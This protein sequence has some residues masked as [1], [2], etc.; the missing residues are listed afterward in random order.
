M[1][2]REQMN[3]K[4]ALTGGVVIGVIVIAAAWLVHW[5][6]A[7]SGVVVRNQ[8]YFSDDDGK[9]YYSDA[10]TNLAPYTHNGRDAVIAHVFQ[11]GSNPPFI[12]YLEKFTD[13]MK[14]QM[15]QQPPPD[16]DSDAGTLVK[17]PG[18][19]DWELVTDSAGRTIRLSIVP[20]AGQPGQPV[21]VVP[22]VN[23]A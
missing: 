1:G 2:L 19:K 15:S 4:P 17:R 10:M 23:G 11:I 7:G 3:K 9:S 6:G 5:H 20:P 8:I 22:G 13:D 18:D 14:A 16:V 21:P 12:A